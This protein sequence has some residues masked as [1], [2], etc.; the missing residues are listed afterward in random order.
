MT[1][2]I[3]LIGLGDIG[4]KHLYN[5]M[6]LRDAKLVAVADASRKSR[7]LAKEVNVREV[8]DDYAKLLENPKV[9]CVII[10]LPNFLHAECAIMAAEYGKHVLVEKPLARNV[11]E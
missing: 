6:Q 4:K 3:G 10:S 11:E 8:Y 5:A 1:V 2:N 7:A 9:D